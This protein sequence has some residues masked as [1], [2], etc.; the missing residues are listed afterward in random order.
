MI[1]F[2]IFFISQLLSY[3]IVFSILS[4]LLYLIILA[5][6][7]GFANLI[8]NEFLNLS[9]KDSEEIIRIFVLSNWKKLTG[10]I[11]V[12]FLCVDFIFLTASFSDIIIKSNKDRIVAQFTS[13]DTA[14]EQLDRFIEN[15][16]NF[17]ESPKFTVDVNSS[18]K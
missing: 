1:T 4:G 8:C 15:L 6:I 12:G 7:Y 11:I 5:G 10:L 17:M 14:I 3:T 9:S 16:Q 18:K 2:D 13:K